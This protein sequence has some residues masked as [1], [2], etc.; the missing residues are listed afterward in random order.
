[1][2]LL[3]RISVRSRQHLVWADKTGREDPARRGSGIA[4]GVSETDADII[5]A[6]G[7][8]CVCMHTKDFS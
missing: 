3:Y 1:M 7:L 2:Y 5:L 6:A 8:V 4:A